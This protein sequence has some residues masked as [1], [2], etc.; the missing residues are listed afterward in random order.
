MKGSQ[1]LNK[2]ACT[3]TMKLSEETVSASIYFPARFSLRWTIRAKNWRTA[4]R[5]S[6]EARTNV[7]KTWKRDDCVVKMLMSGIV[8]WVILRHLKALESPA[9]TGSG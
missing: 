2:I 9:E 5:A 6:E 1:N 3:L 8:D 4:S 7:L